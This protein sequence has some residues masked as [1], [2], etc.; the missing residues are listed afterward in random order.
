LSI[1]N[2]NA[3]IIRPQDEKSGMGMFKHA[4]RGTIGMLTYDSNTQKNNQ[5]MSHPT[6]MSALRSIDRTHLQ[7]VLESLKHDHCYTDKHDYLYKQATEILNASC[8][9]FAEQQHMHN[10]YQQFM[11]DNFHADPNY[12]LSISFIF[13]VTVNYNHVA[14]ND[15]RFCA[16]KD[17]FSSLLQDKL[18]DLNKQSDCKDIT[19]A[20]LKA[21]KETVDPKIIEK[22]QHLQHVAGITFNSK[23]LLDLTA[24]MKQSLL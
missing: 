10:I 14:E 3:L 8:N 1:R 23:F 2:D 5:V 11:W 22:L 13:P 15:P 6:E 4:T 24:I 17:N 19:F 16:F 20:M 7:S 18:Y 21:Y 12:L 9:T